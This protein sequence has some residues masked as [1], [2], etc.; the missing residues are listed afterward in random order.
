VLN[1]TELAQF[2]KEVNIDKIRATNALYAD[3]KVPV[4]DELIPAQFRNPSQYGVGTNWFDAVTRQGV[5]Q[6]NNISVNGGT[7]NIKYYVSANY[8]K[9]QSVLINND[10]TRYS[11]RSNIDVRISDKL[12]FGLNL[13]PSRTE[14][15]RSADE[16]SSGQ[17]SAGSTITSTYWADPSAPLYSSPNFLSYTTKGSITTNWT[18]NPLYQLNIEEEKR[19]GS[20]LASGGYLEYVP[21]KNLTLKS[22]F[23]YNYNYSRSRNFQPSTLLVG[24]GLTGI[25]PNP[26]GAKAVLFNTATNNFTSDNIA[27]YRFKIKKHSFD[28]M[29]GFTLQDVSTESSSTTA[30]RLID[31]NFKLPDY[32]NVD[33][34]VVGNYVGSEEFTQGRLLS[35][36][37][38]LNYNFA[39]K[40]LLNL[41]VRRDGSSRFGRDVQYGTFPAG[42]F[43]WRASNEGFLKKIKWLN[44]LRFEVGYGLTGNNTGI[45]AYTHLGNIAL[46]N[47]Y[48]FNGVSVPGSAVATLPN[49]GITWEESKQFDAGLNAAF[50]NNKIKL[51]FN[52]YQQITEGLLAQI[53]LSWVTGFGNVYGNQSSRIRNRGFEV[54]I[55]AFPIRNKKLVWQTS[56]NASRYDNLILEY[57]DSRGFL[58]AN[59]GNG[60]QVTISAPGQPI[61]MYRGLKILGLFTAADMADASVAKYDGA[62]VGSLKYL[63]GNGNGKLEIEADYVILGNPHPDL[64]FGWNN[65][66]HYKG[67]S[68]RTIF[69][70]Q[71]GGLIYDLRREIMWNVDGNFNIDRQMLDRFRPGDDPTTKTFPTTVST[72][73]STT[74]YVRFPSN[75]KIYDGTYVAL[76]NATLSYN[77][78][79]LLKKRTFMSGAEVYASVR[80]AFFLAA[81][82][83]GNPE[84][85][86]TREGSAGRSIN[87]GSFPISRTLVFGLNVSF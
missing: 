78:N 41:S 34:T 71:L 30:Q 22:N 83:Y 32:N 64:M 81:Y 68:F 19:R 76:K 35:F 50:L 40:Y 36:L 43:T 69:S 66:V 42:S 3:S 55:D 17:F 29:G 28:L 86:R 47:N 58:T 73:G 74:R 48:G 46:T 61:G 65:T 59:A 24:D 87:Y 85:R 63:D 18:A 75:N 5:N 4:P 38:R 54:Q 10:L 20:Q 12:K 60:T 67:F 8:F 62:R 1:A 79:T 13:A 15:N 23:S 39:N 6:N 7:E 11:F 53:P 21:L 82:K 26:A 45:G 44:D 25:L 51:S 49:S 31:E 16:P 56:I 84:V 57:F 70:G 9:N 72:S 27:Q 77:L 33:K 52:I 14:Q 2:Y 37:S 80:N